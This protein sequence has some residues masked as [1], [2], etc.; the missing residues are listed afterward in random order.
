MKRL[1]LALAFLTVLAVGVEPVL[2]QPARRYLPPPL[3]VLVPFDAAWNGVLLTVAERD[4]EN[5]TEDR[6]QGKVLTEFTEYS[7]GPLA[8][9]HIAKVGERPKLTDGEWVRVQYQFDITVQLIQER[10]NLVIVY[11]NIKALKR[12]FLGDEKWVDIPSNGRLEEGLLTDFGKNLF[13]QTFTL[14]QPKKGFW[15]RDPGY[16]PEADVQPQI[17][18]PE[19]KRP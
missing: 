7:S 19:R 4:L 9:S 18:G 12:G 17:V 2:G 10:E 6:G 11:A 13:G 3:K 5:V 1:T 15:E 14:S 16:V 8:E